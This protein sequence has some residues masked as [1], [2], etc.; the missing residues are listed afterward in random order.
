MGFISSPCELIIGTTRVEPIGME[1]TEGCLVAEL[2]GPALM[3]VLDATFGGT[4]VVEI[5]TEGQGPRA[6]SVTEIAMKGRTTL[7]TFE[8][9]GAR[10][11]IN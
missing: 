11:A 6:M 5:W 8:D 9:A 4:G 7:V 2:A 3:S 10:I 1:L